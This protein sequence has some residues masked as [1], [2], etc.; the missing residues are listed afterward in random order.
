MSN[1]FLAKYAE[2]ITVDLSLYDPVTQRLQDTISWAAGDI[3]VI[4]DGVVLGNS[5]NLPSLVSGQKTWR[6]A[7]TAAE[8]TAKTIML[9]LADQDGPVFVD[10]VFKIQTFGD[11]L[12]AIPNIP[13]TLASGAINA[14][15]LLNIADA[16]L[17][18]DF[19]AISGEAARSLLNAARAIRNNVYVSG[20]NLIVTKEDDSTIAWQGALTTDPTASPITGINPT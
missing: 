18:R 8:V 19:S 6:L 20:S 5:T 10:D 1:F 17:K 2:A 15:E 16:I 11:A 14:S 13:A 4:R 7:L 3:K 12:S 9:Q